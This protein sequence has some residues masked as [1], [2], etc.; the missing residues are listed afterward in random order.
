M[1]PCRP[2]C[3][4]FRYLPFLCSHAWRLA[5]YRASC[6]CPDMDPSPFERS[7]PE[8]LAEIIRQ[9][10][11]RLNAQL[12]TG[13]AADQ[14]AMTFASLLLATAI[15][16]FAAALATTLPWLRLVILLSVGAGLTIAA[17]MAIWSAQPSDWDYVGNVPSQWLTDVTEGK[18]LHVSMAET[19]TWYD[20]MIAGNEVVI[21]S[22]ATIMRR[23]MFLAV[24]TVT[25]GTVGAATLAL[26]IL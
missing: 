5:V 6:K 19:A 10:E 15:V 25:L 7:S 14:R 24:L 21:A 20:E 16:L 3:L 17:S 4:S 8:M 9:A 12:T 23:A 22:A 13:V 26:I 18:T 2:W 1:R 11:A